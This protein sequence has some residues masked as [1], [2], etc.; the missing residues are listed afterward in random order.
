[1]YKRFG[2]KM[3]LFGVDFYFWQVFIFR[4]LFICFEHFLTIL[5]EKS[6]KMTK[7]DVRMVCVQ[8]QVVMCWFVTFASVRA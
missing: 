5:V 3:K 6:N 7:N 8:T 4:V 2:L 1:M